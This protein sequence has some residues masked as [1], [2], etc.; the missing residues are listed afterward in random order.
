MGLAAEDLSGGPATD[1]GRPS[2]R[3]LGETRRGARRRTNAVAKLRTRSSNALRALLAYDTDVTF[4]Q[5]AF[6]AHA[7]WRKRQQLR[8]FR[9]TAPSLVAEMMR[10][11]A[12]DPHA[13]GSLR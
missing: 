13:L 5:G 4:A 6:E 1:V 8:H 3:A 9:W 7:T 11:H 2:W 10:R 12:L